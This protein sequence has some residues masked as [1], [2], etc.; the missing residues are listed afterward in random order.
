MANLHYAEHPEH[1]NRGNLLTILRW[2]ARV[3]SLL[4]TG[5]LL[6]FLIGEGDWTE[7]PQITPMEWISVTL[8][9]LGV[10]VGM[11][12]AWW[13]E[14]TG[15]VIGLLALAGFYLWNVAAYGSPPRG[16]YFLLFSLPLFLFAAY[17]LLVRPGRHGAI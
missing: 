12:I 9:P 6:L 5:V 17:G 15:A 11:M 8:F 1:P 7:V 10:I 2:T 14:G 13:K 16:R 3:T 4:S